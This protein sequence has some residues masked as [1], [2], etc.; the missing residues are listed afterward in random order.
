VCERDLL[1]VVPPPG[2]LGGPEPSELVEP[3][4]LV[5]EIDRLLPQI[6]APE[7]LDDPEWTENRLAVDRVRVALRELAKFVAGEVVP[8]RAHR[9]VAGRDDQKRR[10]ERYT[11]A[12]IAGELARW[13]AMAQ[14]IAR[15]APRIFAADRDLSRTTPPR[16]RF[17]RD[18]VRA[19]VGW[20][21]RGRTGAGRLDVVTSDA[22]G[23]EAPGSDL[24]ACRL[25]GVW[26]ATADL[27]AACFA[28]AELV[29]C[30]LSGADLEPSTFVGARLTRCELVRA[31]L[32]ETR[33]TRAQLE[34]VVLRDAD[35][36][37]ADLGRAIL[38][39]C[40]LRGATL[41]GASLAGARLERAGGG[42]A[43][44]GGGTVATG[45]MPRIP[46]QARR[47]VSLRCA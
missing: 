14:R 21:A 11:R 12:W 39:R 4:E 37:R 16:G 46:R 20:L 1:A 42:A 28:E 26:L 34:R 29:E 33:W 3:V 32:A 18:A 10:P 15:D 24:T 13:D 5:R 2:E 38:V 6:G 36:A 43:P 7:G 9:G 31:R 23:I 25:E 47:L 17:D 19:H 40:D 22:R 44:R 8:A 35:L 45:L 30:D 41:A 27:R